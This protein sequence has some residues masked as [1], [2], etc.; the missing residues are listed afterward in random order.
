MFIKRDIY[1]EINSFL[2]D[3]VKFADV[4]LVEGARQVGKTELCQNALAKLSPAQRQTHLNLEFM[5][6]VKLEIDQCKNFLEFQTLL[7]HRFKFTPGDQAV[8]F[9]DEAQESTKLGTFIRFMK[10]Q[11]AD[12]KCL[13]TGSSM[14]KLFGPDVRVPV[15][16]IQKIV[17]RP[18][19]FREFLRA[20][21]LEAEFGT[22]VSGENMP[23]DLTHQRL[24]EL[25]D[26]YM[27]VGGLP[28]AVVAH[29]QS[30]EFRPIQKQV[31]A[32]Q[33]EDFYR[34]ERLKDHL[35]VDAM[36]TVANR[37]G[38]PSVLSSI[39]PSHRDA[40]QVIEALKEWHLIHETTQTGSLSTQS[41]H[42]KWYLY[43][44]GI[45]SFL[46][47][48]AL[49]TLSLLETKDPVL[50]TPI[51]G[52]VENATLLNLLSARQRP[53]SITGWKKNNNQPIEVDFVARFAKGIIEQTIPIEVKA[54]VKVTGRDASNL[55]QYLNFAGLKYGLLV[56]LAKPSKINFDDLSVE[57]KPVYQEINP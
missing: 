17:I 28:A 25:F 32:S 44:L 45:L 38:Q 19:S 16:R 13:L 39:T 3:S 29:V 55:I 33:R 53:I 9:I 12:T 43:D 48:N 30:K 4:C 31:F 41:F 49:P 27:R 14:T 10:E 56:S 37:L 47:M 51:G 20:Q 57:C 11:W 24:L 35:F 42:P 22:Y 52:F 50:R 6:E 23:S 2:S 46:R 1:E 40:R 54:A 26:E 18:F 8:L 34:K 5:P 36:T 7:A 15:G 21:D